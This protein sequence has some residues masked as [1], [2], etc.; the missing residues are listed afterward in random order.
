MPDRFFEKH[1]IKATVEV[2]FDMT[3][4]QSAGNW[5]TRWRSVMLTQAERQLADHLS[6]ELKGAAVKVTNVEEVILPIQ[7]IGR[8]K[9]E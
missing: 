2:E 8:K 4:E 3:I 1:R 5:N 6:R 7:T 9:G